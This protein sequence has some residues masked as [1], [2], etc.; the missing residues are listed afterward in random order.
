MFNYLF[1]YE[2]AGDERTFETKAD[3][4]EKAV[5]DLFRFCNGKN[6]IFEKAITAFSEMDEIIKLFEKFSYYNIEKVYIADLIY[7]SK[8]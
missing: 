7:K 2:Y 1:V 3:T 8:G 5:I 4:F 6:E